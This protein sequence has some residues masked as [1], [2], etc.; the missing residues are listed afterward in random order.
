MSVVLQ[1][2]SSD[3]V[4]CVFQPVGFMEQSVP[5]STIEDVHIVSRWDIGNKFCIRI[6]VPDGSILLQVSEYAEN[7]GFAV[8]NL[9]SAVIIQLYGK[10]LFYSA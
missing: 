9:N 6:T 7:I 2:S 10:D 1:G 5:Y 3:D 4:C 8:M